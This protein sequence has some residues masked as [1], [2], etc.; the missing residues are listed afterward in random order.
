MKHYHRTVI[1][2]AVVALMAGA[3]L[4]AQAT[5]SVGAANTKTATLDF[6]NPSG[7]T[8]TLTPVA[9]VSPSAPV[10]TV[11]ADGDV[12]ALDSGSHRFAV[13]WT[14]DDPNQSI[15]GDGWSAN[16]RGTADASH[17][18]SAYLKTIQDTSYDTNLKYW[19]ANSAATEFTY[20]IKKTGSTTSPTPADTYVISLDAAIYTA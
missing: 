6:S 10:D 8:H 5:P 1:S 15:S 9:N 17:V 14:P 3:A 16:I 20:K 2:A 18:I 19:V 12:K 11:L 4:P 13:R 7:V